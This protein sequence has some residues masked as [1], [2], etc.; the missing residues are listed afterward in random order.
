MSNSLK[1][2]ALVDISYKSSKLIR[3]ELKH[4]YIP[5][6]TNNDLSLIRHNIHR[7]RLSVHPPLPSCIEELHFALKLKPTWFLPKQ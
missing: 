3:L 5:T 1:R 7:A 2:K 6:W 4:G